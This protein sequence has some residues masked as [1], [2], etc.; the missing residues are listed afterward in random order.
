[1]NY[2]LGLNVSLWLLVVVFGQQSENWSRI[3]SFCRNQLK[4]KDTTVIGIGEQFIDIGFITEEARS[5]VI[6]DASVTSDTSLESGT[7]V[8]PSTC[9]LLV[10]N[11][12]KEQVVL[13]AF[14]DWMDSKRIKCVSVM[15]IG[16]MKSDQ[17]SLLKELLKHHIVSQITTVMVHPDTEELVIYNIPFNCKSKQH[18]QQIIFNSSRH[19]ILPE[20]AQYKNT[21][22]LG[23]M[24]F[25]VTTSSFGE[26][27]FA[28][29]E[30]ENGERKLYGSEVEM[31]K[32]LSEMFGFEVE[33]VEDPVESMWGAL[34]PNGTWTGIVGKVSRNE[35]DIGMGD[36]SIT[37]NRMQVVDYTL[38]YHAEPNALIYPK[39]L[40]KSRLAVI[41]QPFS[42]SLWIMILA[43][44]FFV[45]VFFSTAPGIAPEKKKN[46]EWTEAGMFLWGSIIEQAVISNPSKS[47]GRAIVILWWFF[48]LVV[49]T[50]YKSEL[51]SQ[52]SIAKYPPM[53]TSLEELSRTQYQLNVFEGYAF[54]AY[55][56]SIRS[57]V[58]YIDKLMNNV[59]LLNSAERFLPRQ[60]KPN[61]AHINEISHILTF[62]QENVKRGE[63]I[64]PNF[65]FFVTG[66]GWAMRK[67]LCYIDTFSTLLLHF[68]QS[69]IPV[70]LMKDIM[71]MPTIPPPEK[72]P[73]GMTGAA[74]AFVLLG[75]GLLISSL[76]FVAEVLWSKFHQK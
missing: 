58:P 60:F 43:S 34:L 66:L 46:S 71:R 67:N 75:S 29:Y 9:L 53:I 21:I 22:D 73:L 51:T 56:E 41:V 23:Q 24:K 62:Y 52:L 12:E 1:M 72:K 64:V 30:W 10:R 7:L 55:L 15:V 4:G 48:S 35:A 37:L 40:P 68:S 57:Q 76:V 49:V 18:S 63:F 61:T 31:I 8:I 27:P 69:G 26:T 19:S 25:R 59:V 14:D 6:I 32:I 74:I 5:L 70:H 38:P 20:M 16:Q 17:T 50:N 13:E 42:I 28:Y 11:Q 2:G 36:L 33:F 54:T 39:P 3:N 44:F 45:F 65:R 47:L